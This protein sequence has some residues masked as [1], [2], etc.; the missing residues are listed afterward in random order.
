MSSLRTLADNIKLAKRE[1]PELY[2][3]YKIMREWPLGQD[4][5]KILSV[6]IKHLS[7]EFIAQARTMVTENPRNVLNFGFARTGDSSFGTNRSISAT[8]I[9]EVVY[10]NI[11]IVAN[12]EG[13]KINLRI[14]DLAPRGLSEQ[15][16]NETTLEQQ[17]IGAFYLS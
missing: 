14:T 1:N 12:K 13:L 8:D 11:L 17:E 6:K 7:E 4:T 16:L 9:I 2:L 5:F 10:Q 3:R 15:R